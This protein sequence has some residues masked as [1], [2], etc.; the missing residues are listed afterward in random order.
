MAAQP[1]DEGSEFGSSGAEAGI[2]TERPSPARMY[3]YSLGGKDNFA[4]DR[5]AVEA[6]GEI[7]P[8]FR[9]VGLA[10]RGFLVRAVDTMA[11]AGIDQFL[12]IGTG[13]PTSPSVHEIAQRVHPDA[14]VVYIDNDPIVMAHNRALRGRKPG[15]L[16]LDRDLHQPASVLESPE[17]RAHLDFE[18][19][20]G[21]IFAA[22]LHFVR[23][24]AAVEVV[25][26]FRRGLP[27]G[28]YLAIS[29]ACSDG[30]DAALIDRLASVYASSPAP[31]VLRT[32]AQIE[33]LFAGV[34]LLEPGL[35]DVTQWRN[36]GSPLP[37][38]ILSGVGKVQPE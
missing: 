20:I 21:L 7:V 13:I 34:E 11:R 33:E 27:P 26:E 12:D 24:E 1:H 19:P 15:V 36:D 4:V 29:A 37:I 23:L 9:S 32:T 8:E 22:V 25:N 28:S 10:N 38:R 16:T 35:V 30:M 6:V 14:R 17:V 31:M 2:D 5:A 18:R 3:D